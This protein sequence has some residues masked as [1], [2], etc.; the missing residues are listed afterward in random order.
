[1]PAAIAAGVPLAYS[2][3]FGGSSSDIVT[4]V[5][6]DA[7]GNLYLAGYTNSAD[8]PQAGPTLSSPT[9]GACGGDE[10]AYTCFD[11][12]IAKLDPTGQRLIFLAYLG[13]SG[14]D[15]ATSIAVDGNANVYI[16]GYTNSV[17]LPTTSAVQPTHAGDV[18]G[19]EAGPCFDAFVAKLN[20]DGSS[21]TYVTYLGGGGDDLAQAIA[22]DGAG[23][24]VI[25]GTTTS[26]NF[27]TR[28]A[29]QSDWG[30]GET[31]SFIAKFGSSGLQLE[32]ATYLGGSGDDFST[33]VVLSA[34][35]DIYLAGYTN[36]PD[37]RVTDSLQPADAGGIC[38][39][40]ES[41]FPCFDAYVARLAPDGSTFK[42]MTYLGGTG[43]DYAKGI[44]V[45]G[46]GV[47]TVVGMTTS[48]DFPVTFGAFQTAGGGS[49]TDAF[50]ARLGP[51]GT[52]LI[53]STYLG[54]KGPESAEAVAVEA[55][56]RAF[57]AGTTYGGGFPVMNPSGAA[58]GFYDVFLAVLNED[59]T[60]LDFSTKLGGAGNDKAHGVALDRFGNAY[61]AVE[62]F[63]TD[64]STARALQPNYGGGAF[65]G[66]IAKFALGEFPVLH[67]V[68]SSIDFGK[69]H[70]ETRS[71]PHSVVFTNIGAGELDMESF[72]TSG[73]F[74]VSGEC[75]SLAP[76]GSCSIE[77]VFAP[78]SKGQQAG[79]LNVI[80]NGLGEMAQLE[81]TGEGIAPEI[82]LSAGAVH[83]DRQLV[84]TESGPQDIALTNSGTAALK[85]SEIRTTGDFIESNDCP[86]TI[87]VDGR[88]TI[89]VTFSPTMPGDRSGS[90]AVANSLPEETRL[91]LLTGSG[92][93]FDLITPKEE[94]AVSAGGSAT[95]A[96]KIAPGGGFSESVSLACAGVPKA[97]T[98]SFSQQQIVL[99]GLN[100]AE[101]KV[102]VS[103]TA[104]SL[105][106]PPLLPPARPIFPVEVFL[107]LVPIGLGMHVINPI[108]RR[109]WSP[110]LALVMALLLWVA[111]CGGGGNSASPPAG[112]GTPAGTYALTLTATS[113][114]VSKSS[115][116]PLVVR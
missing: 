5:T 25:T 16:T 101:V 74:E 53:Y 76:G 83:F 80:H 14:D 70:V 42:Y 32:F 69:Q 9:P 68:P 97:A 77:L 55:G 61:L 60:G 103:T 3:Y 86:S 106:F 49:Q 54:G 91:A 110:G 51:S 27:P 17:D 88:C 18:C 87:P 10:N 57:I 71:D 67:A 105:V 6:A 113:G 19:P 4:A 108:N 44:A 59:G 45:D 50:V 26:R 79:L 92:T 111:A 75:A 95:V 116:I 37:L 24:A 35:G 72:E 81:L 62:T 107:L 43:G 58:G 109:R 1:M 15:Y 20:S 99:D 78:W 102:T 47:A 114:G 31:E 28:R 30:G 29:L 93:D 112:R 100:A 64:F 38:G 48:Q 89:H 82:H 90:L 33:G 8:L 2:T 40:L 65:D 73:D 36:S 39:A 98:C 11:A 85:L 66:A 41:T 13:G 96:I 46:T 34:G 22:V 115:T 56:G 7:A 12:F 94:I 63:S 84:G 23:S 21:W 52:S 104:R